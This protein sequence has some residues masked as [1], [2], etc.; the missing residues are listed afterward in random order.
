[1]TIVRKAL[2]QTVIQFVELLRRAGLK[3]GPDITL[4]TTEALTTLPPAS[5]QDLYWTLYGCMVTNREQHEIF[6]Q[7]FALYWGHA[8]LP[9]SALTVSLPRSKIK[10]SGEKSFSRRTLEAFN[11]NDKPLENHQAEIEKLHLSWSDREHLEHMDF[12]SMSTDEY[13]KAQKILNKMKMIFK[14]VTTRRFKLTP[15]KKKIDFRNSFKQSVRMSGQ[16]ITLKYKKPKT[17]YPTVLMLIDISGSMSRYARIMLQFA[18]LL[19]KARRNVHVYVFATRLNDVSIELGRGD[20]DEALRCV[21]QKVDDF[22]S[23]TRI[24]ECIGE[25]N[26]SHL[27]RRINSQSEVLFVSDGLDRGDS[28]MLKKQIGRLKRSCRRL[29]WLNPLLRYQQYQPHARG[30]ST[31]FPYADQMLA[32]HNIASIEQLVGVL[33][34]TTASSGVKAA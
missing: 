2:I 31:I 12:D 16:L 27:K 21:G 4:K 11:H 32:V 25:F 19:T 14:P 9:D 29:I 24:G 6:T 3:L 8:S 22:N 1:M 33:H 5:H 7:V 20:I 28:E 18:Y 26:N 17:C 34:G 10:S 15:Q 30:A 13:L 23:G